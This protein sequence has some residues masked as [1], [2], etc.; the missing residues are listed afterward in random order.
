MVFDTRTFFGGRSTP[1][2]IAP[3]T[4]PP[5]TTP[6]PIA[7]PA[8]VRAQTTEEIYGSRMSPAIANCKKIIED[9][10]A[11]ETKLNNISKAIGTELSDLQNVITTALS[12]EMQ[13]EAQLATW[14][15]DF[16][17]HI[18]TIRN[19]IYTKMNELA[20][21]LHDT[22]MHLRLMTGTNIRSK[23]ELAIKY[24][25]TQ[26]T[27]NYNPVTKTG[28]IGIDTLLKDI[29]KDINDVKAELKKF[30][31]AI[32][33]AEPEAKIFGEK[34]LQASASH[35]GTIEKEVDDNIITIKDLVSNLTKL[36][37]DLKTIRG[38]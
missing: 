7:P 25:E 27:G 8:T 17:K 10:K 16:K 31:D 30:M 37:E 4:T 11:T 12:T 28:V 20:R 2:P 38:L 24:I 9:S 36:K 1:P 19:D 21:R 34:F 35:A 32:K 33:S 29:E 14:I 13:K 3:P 15:S 26:F 22:T 23:W 18:T 5:P 6:P